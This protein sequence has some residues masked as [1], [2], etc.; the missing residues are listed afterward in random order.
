[1]VVGILSYEVFAINNF[2]ELRRWHFQSLLLVMSIT[3]IDKIS[4][5]S[6][7]FPLYCDK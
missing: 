1:M 7:F 4:I 3:L 6:S 2:I 5:P